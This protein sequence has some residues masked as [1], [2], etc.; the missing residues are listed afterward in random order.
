MIGDLLLAWISEVGEGTVADF[1]N[2]ASWLAR[3]ENLDLHE[4]APDRWLRCSAALGH[5]EVD[6]ARGVWSVSPSVVAR[7]PLADGLAVLAG[8]R[9]HRLTEALDSAGVYVERAIRQGS[10]RDI[11]APSTFL[12][13][14]ERSHDLEE[15]ANAIGAT[16]VGCAAE[17]IARLLQPT[18]P[19][20]VSAP[21][22]YDSLLEHLVEWNPQR[23]IAASPRSSNPPD[24]LYR[25]QI[26]GR[27]QH[28]FRRGSVWHA[29]DLSVGVFAELARRGDSV[30]RW[31]PD[32]SD[33]TK[34]GTLIIDRRAPLPPLQWRALVLCSGFLPRLGEATETAHYDNVPRNIA[35][36]VTSSLGQSMQIST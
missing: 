4:S 10:E 18:E 15:T 27:W 1:R 36:R 28:L 33:R 11:P 20:R 7:L 22:A 3:S 9:R 2:R 31:R 35:T 5:C 19:R 30:V 8:A 32:S 29:T 25:E 14:F 13:P 26:N 23:W 6:W 17:G 16:Y 24:G 21:P 12:I 34:T